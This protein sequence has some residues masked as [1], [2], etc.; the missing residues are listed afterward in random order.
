MLSIS[1]SVNFKGDLLKFISS[2]EFIG[3]KW[4]WAWGT[5]NPTTDIPILSQVIFFLILIATLFAKENKLF[6]EFSLRLKML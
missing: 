2:K 6:Y 1:S 4:I 5:S 3:I